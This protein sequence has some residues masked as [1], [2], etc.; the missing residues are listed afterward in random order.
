MDICPTHDG[1]NSDRDTTPAT[2]TASGASPCV[3]ESRGDHPL[4]L[5]HQ[6]TL[7][8]LTLQHA[9]SK[10]PFSHAKTIEARTYTLGHMYMAHAGQELF[11][12][13]TRGPRNVHGGVVDAWP[14]FS[15]PQHAQ[16]VGTASFS[17]SQQYATESACKQ[18]RHT[19]RIKEVGRYDWGDTAKKMN[20]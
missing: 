19:H 6:L 17:S 1:I 10:F 7:R 13:E 18:D 3:G 20:A 16:V 4:T 12:I 14:V 5:A 15:P 9:F 11:L 8:G 2:P